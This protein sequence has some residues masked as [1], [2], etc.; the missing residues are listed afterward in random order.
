MASLT[1]NEVNIYL[2]TG[3]SPN[4]VWKSLVCATDASLSNSAEIIE[5]K[6][7]CGTS[8]KAGTKSW[9]MSFTG[10]VETSPSGTEVSFDALWTIFAGQTLS[11]FAFQDAA[12]ANIGFEGDAYITKFDFSA[13][14]D[15][16][17][18]FSLT[19]SGEGDLVIM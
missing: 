6:T 19:L 13:G 4:Y 8:R 11:H 7:K 2:R 12:A 17:V 18:T 14:V 3:T 10:D 5:S 15:D 9:E 1:G 16:N